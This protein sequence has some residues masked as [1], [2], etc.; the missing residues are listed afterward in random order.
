MKKR[1]SVYSSVDKTTL[2]KLVNLNKVKLLEILSKGQKQNQLDLKKKMKLS[3]TETRRYINSLKDQGL[4]K[5]KLIKKKRGSPVF[6][7]LK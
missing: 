1:R 3:Y 6:I 7:S 5:K 2:L 4:V